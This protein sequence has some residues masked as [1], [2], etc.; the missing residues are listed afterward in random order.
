M[1]G[2][3]AIVPGRC[4]IFDCHPLQTK[5][6]WLLS[7]KCLPV[8]I[9]KCYDLTDLF[10]SRLFSEG[11]A[12]SLTNRFLLPLPTGM[13]PQD[14][15]SNQ[16]FLV[17]FHLQI[18]MPPLP[19]VIIRRPILPMDWR[20]CSACLSPSRRFLVKLLCLLLASKSFRHP[21]PLIN[22]GVAEKKLPFCS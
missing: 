2:W 1:L 8:T 11:H 3:M 13:D 9:G 6:G 18:P 4:L 19:N 22:L 12:A 17:V 5:F 14:W 20:R 7:V 21:D 16:P 15:V 10:T